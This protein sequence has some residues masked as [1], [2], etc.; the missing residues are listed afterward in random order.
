MAVILAPHCFL[1][2]GKLPRNR[3][4][5]DATWLPRPLPV[6][7]SH[8]H[9]FLLSCRRYKVQKVHKSKLAATANSNSADSSW[10]HAP[11]ESYSRT[12]EEEGREREVC[13]TPN[14]DRKIST[15]RTGSG[16]REEEDNS[17]HGSSSGGNG[18]TVRF[19]VREERAREN[20][21]ARGEMDSKMKTEVGSESESRSEFADKTG[22]NQGLGEEG[23]LEGGKKEGIW[24][25][26]RGFLGLLRTMLPRGSWWSMGGEMETDDE[27]TSRKALLRLWKLVEPDKILLLFAFIFLTISSLSEVAIPH[28][29]AATIFSAGS[30]LKPR[31]VK[32]AY[33]L[34]GLTVVYGIFSG[35]R[36][37][38][39]TTIN[40]RVVKRLRERLF[41]NI[42]SQDISFFDS[43]GVGD[44]TSRLGSDCQT[45]SRIIGE[46]VNIMSRNTLQG[47]GAL[48]YLMRLCWPLAL[49]TAAVSSVLWLALTAYGRF[50]RKA[51]KVTQDTVA[52][53]NEVAEEVFSLARVVR[54]FGTEKQEV[55]RYSMWGDK[56]ISIGL[57]KSVAYGFWTWGSNTL[58]NGTQVVA[59]FIGGSFVMSGAI[60]AEQLTKYI[61]YA[62]G[63]V[64]CTW[65]VGEHWA[66]LMEAMGASE[67]VFDLLELPLAPQL[68]STGRKIENFKGGVEFRNVSFHYPTRTTMPVLQKVDLVIRPG[69]LVALVGLSGSGKSTL[70]GLLQR[71]YEPT[72][73]QVLVD[74]VPLQEIDI[75]WFRKN[76]G[77]VSQEP[78]LFSTDISSN[79]AYGG[80]EEI[81]QKD[82]EIAAQQANAHDFIVR[83][84]EGYSTLVDNSRLSGGQ[85]QRIAIARALVREP[86]ILILDEATSALDAESEHNVQIALDRA[87]RD[88]SGKRRRTVIV[89]AHRLSTVRAA[90]RIVVM[91]GGQ[92]SEVGSHEELLELN[93]EYARLN[94]R[95][96]NVIA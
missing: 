21:G 14:T 45:V 3:S 43:E 81:C 36:G 63:V 68:N 54:T 29:I 61:L 34:A 1:P 84:P 22:R 19:E 30:G 75:A 82:I 47:L 93:G 33:T 80:G 31:F 48:I 59:L 46:N 10:F 83:L 16:D 79:I 92:I 15:N 5:G 57:R 20:G 95:Q 96:L 49:S 77:V 73:G 42:I 27:V 9:E 76:L 56:L 24:K 67:R 52:A 26:V 74:G 4:C 41:T 71:L 66:Y 89:I 86:K 53:A 72:E 50:Q 23:E 69:E 18:S 65:W 64:H 88:E 94:R 70:M 17:I 91:I 37:G 55:A 7:R 39:F 11:Q 32:N 2:T 8:N 60:S 25:R 38:F 87:M 58:Y 40:Q 90:D 12:E 44:L 35:L 62:E 78:R 13:S 51:A 28:F 85:K 6:P